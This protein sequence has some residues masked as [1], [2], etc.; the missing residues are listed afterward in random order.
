LA[1]G[2]S[3]R[4][5]LVF[6]RALLIATTLLLASGL[7]AP[8]SSGSATAQ[9]D[10][11]GRV[12][13]S[14]RGQ[15]AWLD[16]RAPRPTPVTQLVRPAYPADV[17]GAAGV[18]FAVAS[19]VSDLTGGGAM[20]GDL[21]LIDLQTTSTRALLTRQSQ[22]ESLDLPAIWPDGRAILYQR[23]NLR[24]AVP[25]P[26]QAQPQ[27]QSR[28]EQ[29]DPD[30]GNAV[31]V[32]ED[33]RYPGPA[34]DGAQFAFVRSTDGGTGIFTHSLSDGSDTEL[35][36]PGQFLALAYPRF[37]PDGQSVAFA[38]ISL[39]SPIGQTS[40]DTVLGWL[41][42]RSVLAHGFPW[43]AWI[44]NADGS[45]LRQILDVQNDDPSIAWSPDG[46]QFLVYGGWGS[47][48][49]DATS[50]AASSLSFLAGYGSLAWLPE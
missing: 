33:A 29:V 44:V 37:S 32:L 2:R 16:L 49:V 45:G 28:V 30:G 6:G 46:S 11:G 42:A 38:A 20:G 41:G 27:S 17:A 21:L 36:A 3:G 19:V 12:L 26:G 23:S 31:P 14:A 25:M 48:L 39:L 13:A 43:E 9:T 22:S 24:V 34:P 35:V 5:S 7:P 40:S 15:V 18:P 47:Y 10:V 50:G 1:P 8:A 4:R